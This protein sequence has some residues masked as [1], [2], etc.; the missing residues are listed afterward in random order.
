VNKVLGFIKGN[1][2]IVISIVLI[3]ALLPVGYVFSS[4][5]NASVSEK[6]KGAYDSE[7]RSLTSSG[8]VNYALPAV[9]EGEQDISES[10]APNDAVTAFY[11]EAK[12]ARIAQ[13]EDVV[14]RGTSFNQGDHVE[15]V[16]GLLPKAPNARE[17]QRLG[18][19]MS[20][21]IAGTPDTPSIYQRK[22]RRINAGAPP[23]VPALATMLDQYKNQLEQEYRSANAQG[24]VSQ[25]QQSEIQE[26]LTARRL[27]E[28]ISRAKSLTFYCSPRAFVNGSVT[29]EITTVGNDGFSIVPATNWPPSQ[30]TE[31]VAFTWL[32]DF[33][34]ISDI[35]DAA[36]KANMNAASGAMPVPDAPVKRVE[37]IRVSALDVASGASGTDDDVSGRGFPR[38]NSSDDPIST[39]QGSFTGREGGTANSPFDLR[40]VE[41]TAVVASK[42]LPKFLDSFSKVN[43][44]TVTDVDLEEVDVWADLE[45]GFY[46]GT[47]HVV[48]ARVKVETVWLRSWTTPI[49]PDPVKEAL[50]IPVSNPDEGG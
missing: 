10:R 47:D 33:W 30:V 24:Q 46:Y 18:R 44:M 38:G 19:T 9:L 22:L 48:R 11:E 12:Q 15:I 42:D 6:V 8:K 28:Y 23:S 50:G 27:N 32:W 34:V 16:P 41:V 39:T 1:L 4:K 29:G 37:L 36:A 3:L 43:F 45:Q 20:E 26:K 49:M 13:V 35:L 5:W 2:I 14:E 40:Q 21:A 17:R 7:K 25:E 31:S